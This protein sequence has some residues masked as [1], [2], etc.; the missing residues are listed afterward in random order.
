MSTLCT[1]PGCPVPPRDQ[2]YLCDQHVQAITDMLAELPALITDLDVTRSRQ[3]RISTGKRGTG[4][5]EPLPISVT[6]HETAWAARSTL[7][8]WVRTIIEATGITAW[9][10]DDVTDM[11]VWLLARAPQWSR[12]SDEGAELYAQLRYITGEIT[13]AIDRPE[14]RWYAGPCDAPIERLRLDSVHGTDITVHTVHDTCPAGLWARPG[15][16]EIVCDAW[17]QPDLDVTTLTVGPD[18][19]AVTLRGCRAVHDPLDRQKWLREAA[20]DQLLP[21]PLLIDACLPIFGYQ[22]TPGMVRKWRF[23]RQLVPRGLDRHGVELYRGGDV[24]ARVDSR[25]ARPSRRR[26]VRRLSA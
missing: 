23:R 12:W 26:R 21:L 24:F 15:A 9:P 4:H 14:Q 2:A 22:P 11:A 19:A 6:A 1:V 10:R 25:S 8:A 7:V 5:D 16:T 20:E 18:G 13:R 3:D 17:R